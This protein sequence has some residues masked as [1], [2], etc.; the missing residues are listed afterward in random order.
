MKSHP[1]RSGS[2]RF[3]SPNELAGLAG[4]RPATIY[5]YIQRGLLPSPEVKTHRVQAWRLETLE[6]WLAEMA[7][8]DGAADNRAKAKAA[9][10]AAKAV[11]G[12]TEEGAA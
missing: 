11:F 4:L 7:K 3:V 1:M 8:L 5:Q 12:W 9:K 2:G 10:D 6:P